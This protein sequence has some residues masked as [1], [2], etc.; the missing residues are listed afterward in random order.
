MFRGRL[1]ETARSHARQRERERKLTKDTTGMT[2]INQGLCAQILCRSIEMWMFFCIFPDIMGRRCWSGR[3]LRNFAVTKLCSYYWS[4]EWTRKMVCAMNSVEWI[5]CG[6]PLKN[7]WHG[8][9]LNL[10]KVQWRNVCANWFYFVRCLGFRW[11][12][13]GGISWYL[14]GH[15][16]PMCSLPFGASH[17]H[18]EKT[19]TIT[20]HE[21]LETTYGRTRAT[22]YVSRSCDRVNGGND[23]EEFQWFWKRAGFSWSSRRDMREGKAY[24]Q[25]AA[26]TTHTS[27][28]S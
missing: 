3:H 11:N 20:W 25:G 4:T 8:G 19:I 21:T 13:I 17:S 2:S 9:E 23:N 28:G 10:Q 14:L 12:Q 18:A 24:I 5:A 6:E 7:C 1:C 27:F 26:G 16:S 15:W 22:F